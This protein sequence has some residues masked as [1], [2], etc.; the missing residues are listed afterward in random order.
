[1]TCRYL[2]PGDITV[3]QFVHTVRK[4][5]KLSADKA[6]FVFVKNTLPST[7]NNKSQQL[8]GFFC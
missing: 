8:A 3:G 6:I 7:G 2:V 1:M 5:I 4:K